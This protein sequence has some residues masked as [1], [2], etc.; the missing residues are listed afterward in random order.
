M[1]YVSSF[2]HSHEPKLFLNKLRDQPTINITLTSVM[3]KN[4]E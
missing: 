1:L 3:L 4:Q 2:H